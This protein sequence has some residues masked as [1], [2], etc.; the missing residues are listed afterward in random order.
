MTFTDVALQLL[1]QNQVQIA[2]Q[3][4]LPLHGT[5]PIRVVTTLAVERRRQVRFKDP[6][7]QAQQVPPELHSISRPLTEAFVQILDNMVDLDR[8][9]LDGVNMRI[10]R[11]ETQGKQLIFS[12]Y[13]QIDHFPQRS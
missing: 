1:P 2:A 8:F 9:D 11:L 12:G 5:V 4:N 7:F 6:Q 3:A 13:A 10:N